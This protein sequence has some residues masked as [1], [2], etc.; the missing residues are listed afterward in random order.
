MKNTF[1]IST[2]YWNSLSEKEQLFFRYHA[3]AGIQRCKRII[4]LAN[5]VFPNWSNILEATEL[6]INTIKNQYWV[7]IEGMTTIGM[8]YKDIKGRE[9]IHILYKGKL[10]MAWH[11]KLGQRNPP[12]TLTTDYGLK[13]E[14]LSVKTNESNYIDIP[15]IS[16][17]V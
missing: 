2:K 7:I 17:C 8:I 9:T 15:P 6:K 1:R 11:N 5:R 10:T 3:D 14:L 4:T 13:Y 12:T 16:V